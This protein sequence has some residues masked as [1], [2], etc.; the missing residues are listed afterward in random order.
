MPAT[1]E[2]IATTTLTGTATSYDFTSIPGTYTDLVLVASVRVTTTGYSDYIQFNNDTAGNYSITILYGNGT[3]AAST[4]YSNVSTPY[5]NFYG[6]APS[7]SDTFNVCTIHIMNYS[8]TTTNKTFISRANNA[9]AGTDAIVGMW[10][11]TAAITSLKYIQGNNT[12]ASGTTLT[13]YGIKA[14]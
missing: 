3:S 1:Y 4:R 7:A 2:P 8:N 5:I 12:L 14:A 11:S 10:R 9:A 6:Y 13:L